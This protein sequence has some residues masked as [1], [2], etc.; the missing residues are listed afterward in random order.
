MPPEP[1]WTDRVQQPRPD[2]PVQL[3]TPTGYEWWAGPKHLRAATQ[4]ERD[5]YNA[6]RRD[7]LRP[8]TGRAAK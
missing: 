8:W 6:A 1:P 2:G 5:A 3:V 7:V 4:Q